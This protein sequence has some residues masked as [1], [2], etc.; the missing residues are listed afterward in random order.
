M[1]RLL[2]PFGDAPIP[3][4][5]LSK[6]PLVHVLAQIRFPKQIGLVTANGIDPI[7]RR[8]RSDYPI[9][10]EDRNTAIVLSPEGVTAQPQLETVWRLQSKAGDWQVSIGETFLALDTSAY[11][12]RKDFCERLKVIVDA[13]GAI[14]E[15]IVAERLGLR[16][17]DR[18]DRPEHLERLR[19]FVFPEVLGVMHLGIEN[20]E[21]LAHT[22]TEA[23]FTMPEH[24]L[25]ARWGLLPPGATVDPVLKPVQ[26]RSWIL[27]ID[28]FSDDRVDFATELLISKFELFAQHSYRFFR[29]AVTEELLRAAGGEI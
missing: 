17:I 26:T 9:L 20:K 14:V 15:P 25:L 11:I 12:S 28:V 1:T 7:R 4:V 3:E 16:Y 19:D 27:D 6:A 5:P 29:W 21:R 8:L 24:K 2:D 13:F 23:L 18:I 22:I 10:K